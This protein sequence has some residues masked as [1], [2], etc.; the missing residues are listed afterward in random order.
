[1]STQKYNLLKMECIRLL[2]AI[3]KVNTYVVII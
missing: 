3:M 1:M 2:T